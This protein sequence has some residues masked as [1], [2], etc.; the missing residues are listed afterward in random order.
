MAAMMP[1]RM[2]LALALLPVIFIWSTVQAFGDHDLNLAWGLGSVCYAL[3]GSCFFTR[4]WSD[5]SGRDASLAVVCLAGAIFYGFA[6][7]VL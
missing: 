4:W 6:A 7:V 2:K 1:F 3:I 5:R